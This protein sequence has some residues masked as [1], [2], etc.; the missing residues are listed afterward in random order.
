MLKG[1]V[2]IERSFLRKPEIPQVILWALLLLLALQPAA[3]SAQGVILRTTNAP[4]NV[5][6]VSD[7]DFGNSLSSIWLFTVDIQA[8]AQP[9][10]IVLVVD[11]NATL[12]TGESFNPAI[13]MESH[14]FIVQG[15]RTITNLDLGKGKAL[16]D[17]LYQE[18]ASA[19]RIFESVGLPSGQLPAG[20]Y[21]FQ[22]TVKNPATG[23]PYAANGGFTVTLSNP[24]VID[25]L[26]PVD[27]DRY[28]S[29]LPMFQWQFDGT[30]SK[31]YV[32]EML[33]GQTSVEEAVT[34][35][36]ILT[37]D[38]GTNSYQYPSA[39]VRQLHPGS[40]YAWYV[41]GHV[42]A[43]GGR[44]KL[45]KSPLRSFSVDAGPSSVSS[46]LDEL[47][48]TLDPKYRPLFDQIRNEGL[49]ISGSARDNGST[50]SGGDLSKLL[51][52]LRNNPDAVL[53]VG[54]E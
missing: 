18:D 10:S 34:G 42:I 37:A 4:I 24:S 5:L 50:I 45:I 7:I 28:V 1:S 12:A 27:L 44:D 25:L 19:K 9:V 11:L 40:S 17:S 30:H 2:M 23:T 38:L 41:E 31:L 52:F 15:S 21:N 6:S 20:S 54:L 22:I 48:R 47:E 29:L 35:I 36:P 26:F 13:H 32:Y 49:S 46:L 43:A 53:T 16:P 39:G 51:Q 14:A 3:S 33:P 8:P